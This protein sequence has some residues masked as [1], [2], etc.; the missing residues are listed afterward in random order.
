MDKE[1]ID[2]VLSRSTDLRSRCI[3]PKKNEVNKN[4]IY[5]LFGNKIIE[6]AYKFYHAYRNQTFICIKNKFK[7]MRGNVHNENFIFR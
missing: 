4:N 5:L 1:E 3:V 7:Q 6:R 2:K